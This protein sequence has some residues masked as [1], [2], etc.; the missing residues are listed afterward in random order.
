M[1]DQLRISAQTYDVIKESELG[2]K[3]PGH[4]EVTVEVLQFDQKL[5]EADWTVVLR[6]EGDPD[7][8]RSL[9]AQ[10]EQVAAELKRTA[11]QAE[12]QR[13]TCRIVA[14]T[15]GAPSKRQ[16]IWDPD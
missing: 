9:A 13:E 7:Q 15:Q 6:T 4:V 5:G 16:S 1:L 11:K 14:D 10:F 12:R 2:H 3:T 8:A